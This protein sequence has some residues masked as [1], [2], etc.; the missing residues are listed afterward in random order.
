MS[1]IWKH[2]SSFNEQDMRTCII[3]FTRAKIWWHIF[4]FFFLFFFRVSSCAKKICQ[5]GVWAMWGRF[6]VRTKETV[7]EEYVLQASAY[8]W[9]KI[10]ISLLRECCIS[11]LSKIT[12]LLITIRF[13]LLGHH[14]G[15]DKTI[16]NIAVLWKAKVVDHESLGS[17]ALLFVLLM[18]NV[19]LMQSWLCCE[20]PWFHCVI[21][22]IFLAI[23]WPC[24]PRQ[25]YCV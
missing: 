15:L 6:V 18:I 16:H 13:I 23:S 17:A 22:R 5:E 3:F 8:F 25:G 12:H 9:S 4:F 1:K 2:A 7:V 20:M 24:L 19:M 14:W 10:N 21:K 11:V